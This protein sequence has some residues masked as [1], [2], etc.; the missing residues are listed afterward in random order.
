MK[1]EEINHTC[2]E[3]KKRVEGIEEDSGEKKDKLK[4]RYQHVCVQATHVPECC[5]L[6]VV[7]IPCLSVCPIL[8]LDEMSIDLFV[9]AF[10]G[11]C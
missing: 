11:L 10:V 3:R 4:K 7:S 8:V 5:A 2:Q 9:C 6:D 1:E